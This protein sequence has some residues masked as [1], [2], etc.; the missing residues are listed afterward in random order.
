MSADLIKRLEAVAARLES[1]ASSLGSGASSSSSSGS[2]AKTSEAALIWDSTV[3]P[4][5]DAFLA[6]A[7][8]DANTADL[9]KHTETVIGVIKNVINAASSCSKPSQADLQKF[10]EPA[11]QAIQACSEP[12][13][14][15]PVYDQLKAFAEAS[16]AFLWPLTGPP[17]DLPRPFIQNQLEAS[18]FYLVKV[19]NAS[20]KA[21][22][23]KKDQM[24]AFATTLKKAL[25]DMCEFVGANF[26]TGLE[27]NPK[28]TP[29]SQFGGAA[30]AAPRVGGGA[31]PPPPGPAP[32]IAAMMAA[33]KAASNS[34]S[35]SSGSASSAG[36]GA[37]FG[38][39]TGKGDGVTAG[40]RKVTADMKTKNMKDVPT[41]AP[42]AAEP[43]APKKVEA[44]AAAP[45]KP[46]VTECRK[47]TWFVEYYEGA[48][49][50]IP[51]ELD[52][53]E[54]VYIVGCKPRM[55]RGPRKSSDQNITA[56]EELA[57]AA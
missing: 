6:A 27:W 38:E 36:L 37:V 55:V 7:R 54:G 15:S 21:E 10:F 28:G 3:Q 44:K 31:P 9:A 48:T 25:Q 47:G 49:V 13:L 8:A 33:D 52:I 51:D 16:V 43:A 23:A 22:G 39:L 56:N 30:A 11:Q 19:L 5:I 32:D 34:V 20:K 46:A 50:Q 2:E 1:Y 14:K 29:L 12:A 17:G 45:K 40:L 26:K 53:K 35:S 41:L 57:L 4:S 18:D 42:K 24:A